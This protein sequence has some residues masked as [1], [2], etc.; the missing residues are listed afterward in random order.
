MRHILDKKPPHSIYKYKP[1]T[2]DELDSL[3]DKRVWATVV[4]V[5]KTMREEMEDMKEEMEEEYK[6]A[7]EDMKEEIDNLNYRLNELY[8]ENVYNK[9]TVVELQYY[10]QELKEENQELRDQIKRK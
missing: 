1:Y 4:Y 6:D 10:I 9:D 7:I 3:S 5:I 2:V 8:S